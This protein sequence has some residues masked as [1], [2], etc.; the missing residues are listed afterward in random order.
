MLKPYFRLLLR[1]FALELL[2][3]SC[4]LS[5]SKFIGLWV[6]QRYKEVRPCS[7]TK[8]IALSGNTSEGT[9]LACMKAGMI[10]PYI[11]EKPMDTDIVT[12]LLNEVFDQSVN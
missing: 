9:A 8:F 10:E 3:T 7:R 12:R 11:L 6:T 4:I 2:L 5:P 1:L